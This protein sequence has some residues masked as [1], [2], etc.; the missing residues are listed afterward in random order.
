MGNMPELKEEN[1][2]MIMAVLLGIAVFITYYFHVVVVIE[3]VFT[4]LFYLPIILATMWWKR[5]GVVVAVFLSVLLIFSNNIFLNTPSDINDYFR[6]VMFIL[7]G[8]ISAVLNEMVL[9]REEKLRSFS[10]YTRVLIETSPD[11]LVTISADGK[12]TDVNK[13]TELV[14]G[15]SRDDIIG[16]DFSDYFTEPEHAKEGYETV[17]REGFVKDYP[18]TIR[19]SSGKLTYVLYN[20]SLYKNEAGEV[21]G[22]FAAARDITERKVAEEQ[23]RLASL[24]TRGL[25]E[26]SIDP[27]VTISADGK[28]TDVNKA[29]ELVTGFS[30]D[31]IIGTDFSDYFTEPAHAKEG[32]QQVFKEG[33]VKD[34]PL[35]IRH[36]SGK[37]TDV[38]YNASLYKNEAGEVQGVFAAARDI[39][40]RKVAEEQIRLASLYTRGLLEASIDPLVTISADGKV[41]DVNKATELVTGISRDDII[42]TDFSD[43]FTEPGIAKEGYETVFREGF[44]KDYP[45]TIRHSSGKLTYVLYNAS[46]Y[47]NEAGEVQGVFAAARDIT[48]RKVAEEKIRAASLYT[49]GLIETSIDPLVTISAEGKVTDVNNA[50][51]LVT[52]VSRDKL[53]GTDFSDYFTEPEHAKEGYQQVFK[54]GYVKDYPLT[55]RHSSGKLTDVLYNA[56]LYTNEAGE[57]QGVFAAA[58]D[59][60]ERKVAEEANKELQMVSYSISHDLRTPLRGIDGLSQVLIEDF[61]DKLDDR[62]IDY[63]HRIRAGAQKMSQLIYALHDLLYLVRIDMKRGT[64]NLSAIVSKYADK[65]QNTQPEREVDFV[66]A[67]EVIANGDYYMLEDVLENLLDNAWKF[68]GK[69]PTARIEFGVTKED[70][71]TVYFVRD[72]GAGFDMAYSDKLFGAF[73]R[74]HQESEFP[75]LGVGLITV[76]RIIHRHGG[77][78]WAEGEIEKGATFYFTLD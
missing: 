15:F 44:V 31:D 22:V 35:T 9:K 66:I 16:T 64:V 24:Y 55:I 61:S 74:L 4:H 65:L 32:Y 21:Q 69:H 19:H 10:T 8:T 70:G 60:T 39:T 59:I 52:G 36:S 29:T 11:P 17:F 42:G 49:R 77:K 1:K 71:K 72:D 51:E 37:L 40:E 62:G 50:T 58:R 5:K 30:R 47:K 78:I 43:Y 41:T 14:T 73:Q 54:E 57:V 45:L 48:E 34:Y 67:D 46:L 33:Y 68:T 7:V 18:L 6:A 75:G 2:V 53:I 27:L 23:I 38:L 25:I 76:Q 12:V 28:V 13:A 56:S 3:G 63:L 26:A 20:A